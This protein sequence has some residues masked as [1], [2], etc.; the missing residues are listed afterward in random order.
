M[1]KELK[2]VVEVDQ[3]SNALR[4]FESVRDAAL[5]IDC[6]PGVISTIINGYRK[7]YKG[8]KFRRAKPEEIQYFKNL[9][10]R[11]DAVKEAPGQT[12][13]QPLDTPESEEIPAVAPKPEG[14]ELSAFERILARIQKKF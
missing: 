5:Y 11:I 14:G 12:G 4:Y 6:N 13:E 7:H 8:H 2:P 3:Y 9:I 1:G 10:D